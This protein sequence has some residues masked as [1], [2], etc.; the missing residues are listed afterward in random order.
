MRRTRRRSARRPWVVVLGLRG[1]LLGILVPVA[2]QENAAGVERRV[3]FDAEGVHALLTAEQIAGLLLDQLGLHAVRHHDRLRGALV[4]ERQLF[5]AIPVRVEVV[6]VGAVAV[7]LI[8]EVPDVLDAGL[9][10]ALAVDR[11]R[12]ERES[13]E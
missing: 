13:E 4:V 5:A 2:H 10:I 1:R 7:P 8:G 6:R 12:V 9:G 11:L 3:D